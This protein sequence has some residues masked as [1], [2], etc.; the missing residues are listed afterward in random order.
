MPSLPALARLAAGLETN[1][2]ELL[3]AAGYHES[4]IASVRE[5]TEVE[6]ED[7][8]FLY[9]LQ[10]LLALPAT[11]LRESLDGASDMIADVM[12]AD[13]VDALMYEAE[14]DSLIALGTSNTPMGRRQHQIGMN[15][16]PLANGGREVEVFLTGIP[17]QSGQAK[18]DPGML[19]GM[20]EGLGVQ[21][22]VIVPLD[23]A[24]TRRG[25]LIAESSRPDVYVEADL[26]FMVVVAGWVGM[27]AERAELTER[28]TADAA[29]QARR[30]A[31]EE[32]MTVLAHDL[33]NHLTPLRGHID[34]LR[35]RAQRDN[36]QEDLRGADEASRALRRMQQLVNDLLDASRLEH[37][38]FAPSIKTVDLVELIRDVAGRTGVREHPISLRLPESLVIEADPS[39]LCQSLENLL[40][41][42]IRHSPDNAP[43]TVRLDR[44]SRESDEW[45]VVDVHDEGPGISAD[46]MPA[47]FERFSKDRNSQGL[48][49]GL[50]LAR[51]IAH[52]HGGTLTVDSEVSRGTTFHLALP[53]RSKR[54]T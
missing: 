9:V 40:S 15:R 19:V 7:A 13:K 21:S 49:L 29:E 25:V 17:Y 36:R 43:V 33:N 45:A 39:R 8:T 23:V 41:N 2:F 38:V 24:G 28:I 54:Q 35:R 5:H 50:Y 37:G 30:T 22:L 1:L 12:R 53:I 44:E 3:S 26:T 11:S 27:L 31:A 4:G 18:D 51:G 48:G 20:K 10:K 34:V 16:L 52:A 32:L 47:L 46:L 6:G 42:A 14:S